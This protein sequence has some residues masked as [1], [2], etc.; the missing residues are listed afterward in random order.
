MTGLRKRKYIYLP[1]INPFVLLP[2]GT[3]L[4]IPWKA[5]GAEER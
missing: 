3:A 2:L 5:G 1:E 4:G